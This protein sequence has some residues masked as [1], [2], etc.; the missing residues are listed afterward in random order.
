MWAESAPQ[1]EQWVQ[2]LLT[3]MGVVRMVDS[4]NLCSQKSTF[5]FKL[6]LILPKL[7]HKY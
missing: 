4:E 2:T 1:K 3:R 7:I 5:L 6:L